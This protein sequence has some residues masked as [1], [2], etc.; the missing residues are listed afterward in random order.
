MMNY[1]SSDIATMWAE[2][3]SQSEDDAFEQTIEQL[4]QENTEL[5]R[6]VSRL[7]EAIARNYEE[8]Y[9]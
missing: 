6:Q 4:R 1:S 3:L 8:F 9:E 5:K 2:N 7:R